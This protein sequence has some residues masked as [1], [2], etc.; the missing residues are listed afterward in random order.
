MK[1]QIKFRGLRIDGKGWAYG[2]YWHQK[3]KNIHW[4]VES[5]DIN[6]QFGVA[7]HPE[8]VG[9][10]TGLIDKNGNEIFEND[11]VTLIEGKRKYAVKFEKGCFRLFHIDDKL[12]NMLWG[13]IDKVEV[14]FWSI[15]VIG[16]L[17]EN[18]EL[19]K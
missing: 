11:I 10:F 6:N 19:L 9:Q 14:L 4:I 15:Q 18:P 8:S 1:R 3:D 17:H 5:S 7:V 16:N 12:E 13:S 2:F